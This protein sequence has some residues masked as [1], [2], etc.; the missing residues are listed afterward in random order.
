MDETNNGDACGGYDMIRTKLVEA[1]EKRGLTQEQLAEAMEV[2][3]ATIRRWE[4]GESTP[5]GQ[6]RWR[7][8]TYF[9]VISVDDLDL[10]TDHP[11]RKADQSNHAPTLI[12]LARQG[13]VIRLIMMI[14]ESEASSV[15][16]VELGSK[17]KQE[18]ESG[19]AMAN[20][21]IARRE[22]ILALIGLPLTF[23]HLSTKNVVEKP[24]E[25]ILRQCAAAIT[26]CAQLSKGPATDIAEAWNA[27]SA[28]L[29]SLKAIVEHST[30]HRPAAARLV[31]Q[32]LIQKA[33]I[34]IHL[35]SSRQAVKYAEQA[36]VYAQIS[37]DKIMEIAATSRLTWVLFGD[38]QHHAAMHQA[39]KA[40]HLAKEAEKTKLSVPAL[41]RSALYGDAAVYQAVN[42]YKREAEVALRQARLDFQ[43]ARK[44]EPI[45]LAWD[46]DLLT[47]FEGRTHY[48]NGN[49]R[50]AYE[51]IAQVI[52]PETLQVKMPCFTRDTRPQA[53]NFLT[54]ASL[55]LPEK[56]KEHSIKL[57]EAGLESTLE[58]R[59]EQRFGEVLIGYEM[60]G[61]LWPDDKDVAELRQHIVHW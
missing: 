11:G 40:I 61:A 56:D 25:A 4:H 42:G 20:N 27:L 48:F 6:H 14:N 7:L 13:L 32:A 50:A 35:S 30:K 1:R 15:G 22:A 8:L 49:A 19:Q 53:L 58:L 51:T 59:S 28:Y 34:A 3:V 23:Y 31:A 9:G 18:L 52:D 5:R 12:S 46:E 39:L 24:P 26:A 33:G 44:D 57:W 37:D 47:L 10:D 60:M 45:Y 29:P 16:I 43:K 54:Q 55:K 36:A 17:I 38:K 41:M 21:S 2:D